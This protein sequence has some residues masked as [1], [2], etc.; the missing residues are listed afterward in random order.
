MP[1]IE[2]QDSRRGGVEPWRWLNEESIPR[3]YVEEGDILVTDIMFRQMPFTQPL[4]IY[5]LG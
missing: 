5:T 4:V 1:F 3:D 2:R